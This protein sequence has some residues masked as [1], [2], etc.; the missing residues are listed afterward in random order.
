MAKIVE[1]SQNNTKH[2][3]STLD[4]I[5][6]YPRM[7]K[8]FIKKHCKE[9][10][11]YQTPYLNDVLYLHFKGFSYIEN[12]EEYTGL[13]CLWLENN[14]IREIS[15][16]DN[17]QGLRSLFLHYNLIKKIENLDQCPLLD[18]LNLSYNQ[19]KKI[20]NLANIKNLHT[21]NMANNYVETL[22]DFEHLA[23]LLELSVLDL[24]N[25]HIEDPLIVEVLTRMS[26]LRVLNLM[27]NPVIRKI[28]A[29]RKT[30]ILS[31][32][33]LQYLDDR[34]VFPRDRACAEAWERG[35]IQ[36]EAAERQRWIDRERQKIMDSVNALISMRDRRIQQRDQEQQ[37]LHSDSGFGTSFDGSE[38]E[39]E[40]RAQA[41]SCEEVTDAE[42]LSPH[43]SDSEGEDMVE[44]TVDN[45][46]AQESDEEMKASSSSD[47][48]SEKGPRDYLEFRNRVIDYPVENRT[49]YPPSTSEAEK[50]DDSDIF[51]KISEKV[52]DENPQDTDMCAACTSL[53]RENMEQNIE[54][55]HEILELENTESS[56][57]EDTS[58]VYQNEPEKSLGSEQKGQDKQY[59]NEVKNDNNRIFQEN[60][61]SKIEKDN[62][63]FPVII[64]EL[65]EDTFLRIPPIPDYSEVLSIFESKKKTKTTSS[66]CLSSELNSI[67]ESDSL[68]I[69]SVSV[70][71]TKFE[72]KKKLIEELDDD[73]SI[74][75]SNDKNVHSMESIQTEVYELENNEKFKTEI[76][77]QMQ[78]A[79]EL[80][81]NMNE[82]DGVEKTDRRDNDNLVNE[83]KLIEEIVE[84]NDGVPEDQEQLEEN[85]ID[86]GKITD[87]ENDNNNWWTIEIAEK[88]IKDEVKKVSSSADN[89][90]VTSQIEFD[91][92]SNY[93]LNC[94]NVTVDYIRKIEIGDNNDK[95]DADKLETYSNEEDS[96]QCI[97]QEIVS[98]TTLYTGISNEEPSDPHIETREEKFN[99]KDEDSELLDCNVPIP[100]EFDL[101]KEYVKP[102]NLAEEE[103]LC[104]MLEEIQEICGF[105]RENQ[106]LLPMYSSKQK[107]QN[108][109]RQNDISEIAVQEMSKR[110]EVNIE[111]YSNED[112]SLTVTEYYGEEKA[113]ED[114]K[115]QEYSWKIFNDK[116][117]DIAATRKEWELSDEE[118]EEQ[119][120][121]FEREC[122]EIDRSKH[123]KPDNTSEFSSVDSSP[124]KISNYG[125][126]HIKELREE[127]FTKLDSSKSTE[128]TTTLDDLDG[129]GEN[130]VYVR[131]DEDRE[132]QD[133]NED[134]SYRELLQWDIQPPPTNRVMLLPIQR[135]RTEEDE[136]E[137]D[138]ETDQEWKEFEITPIAQSVDEAT[139]QHSNQRSRSIFTASM[140]TFDFKNTT[141]DRIMTID[142]R[143]TRISEENSTSLNN[144]NHIPVF[145]RPNDIVTKYVN[146]DT[147]EKADGSSV[148]NT[149]II[150]KSISEIRARMAEFRKS[151]DDFN[152][153]SRAAANEIFKSYNDS[154]TKQ[155]VFEKKLFESN[156][157]VCVPRVENK[158]SSLEVVDKPKEYLAYIN[159]DL[160]DPE[161]AERSYEHIK[162]M[163]K[164]IEVSSEDYESAELLTKIEALEANSKLD[165]TDNDLDVRAENAGQIEND[166]KDDT[167]QIT[168]EFQKVS[169]TSKY[170]TLKDNEEFKELGGTSECRDHSEGVAFEEIDEIVLRMNVDELDNESNNVTLNDEEKAVIFQHFN[171][172]DEMEHKKDDND[173]K[174]SQTVRDVVCSLE[175]QLAKEGK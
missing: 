115:K 64:N 170:S 111:I 40:L 130:E 137:D 68:E 121:K 156:K 94:E 150:T 160:R 140:N 73:E 148:D 95:E 83:K 66:A 122:E 126:Q 53:L 133:S 164:M 43:S 144:F 87:Q 45:E 100:T 91:N 123:C 54:K 36:E 113:Q 42:N 17:Q 146:T 171:E 25:N 71:S 141:D 151:L 85:K 166:M 163:L 29:Y 9:N 15:G 138:D 174:T 98:D 6:K 136:S 149:V 37:N 80:N 7:T 82:N 47:D 102:E 129:E 165:T 84:S 90:D 28:P 24:S 112:R 76:N 50:A 52:L 92:D 101:L 81:S 119:F 2:T 12:L 72:N 78:E 67:K 49:G 153:R 27:G 62:K 114:V 103:R 96:E 1:M 104:N 3:N 32:K 44:P 10:R 172:N 125:C 134:Q 58:G 99:E 107:D 105:Q 20:E 41:I 118:L 124:Q 157:L 14:G 175:M 109:G 30:L 128:A 127:F 39:G 120:Q 173:I 59:L 86:I 147:I 117:D 5:C 11:L 63:P 33:N 57:L 162:E 154:L 69:S 132:F 35:G 159:K 168:D 131:K 65:P 143:T 13:K 51:R 167:L 74:V 161:E 16:L 89:E 55:V 145:E 56:Q 135:K 75:R 26:G 142:K 46:N 158:S 110:E 60:Y 18:T 4:E 31:C 155:L 77:K 169:E 34:P 61:D 108:V 19:V 106:H 38:S 152:E 93:H 116:L 70:Q 88:T 97:T 21:L 79:S 23:E 139:V 22:E 48:D 8:E